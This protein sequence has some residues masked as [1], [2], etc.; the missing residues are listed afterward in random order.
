MDGGVDGGMLATAGV[1]CEVELAFGAL[2]RLLMP[3]AERFG[4]LTDAHSHARGPG[5]VV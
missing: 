2:H 1:E 5:I 4:E 3:L